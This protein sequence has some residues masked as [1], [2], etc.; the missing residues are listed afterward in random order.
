M[1]TLSPDTGCDN[2]VI[3]KDVKIHTPFWLAFT[4]TQK[5]RHLTPH[6]TVPDFN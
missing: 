1:G 3:E 4:T 6:P 5:T 2:N